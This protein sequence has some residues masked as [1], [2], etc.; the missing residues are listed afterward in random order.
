MNLHSTALASAISSQGSELSLQMASMGPSITHALDEGLTRVER[1][2]EKHFS[3]LE[4]QWSIT[5]KSRNIPQSAPDEILARKVITPATLETLALFD[6]LCS[7]STNYRGKHERG[8]FR[9]FQHK[10]VHTIAREFRVFNLL[11]CFRLEVER[12]PHAFVRDFKV[13]PNFSVRGRVAWTSEAF[14]LTYK[15]VLKME[16]GLAACELRK[17]FR[18]CLVKLQILFEEGKAWPTDVTR[19][20]KNLLH[21]R[22]YSFF[23][24]DLNCE[25]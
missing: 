2:I 1:S 18:D 12:A 8:C 5:R 10:T 15:T 16:R 3:V 9:L 22:E 19:T 24:I 14:L 23:F 17:T 13:Y 7:C 25:H 21:V 6:S 20:G 11:L 4:E